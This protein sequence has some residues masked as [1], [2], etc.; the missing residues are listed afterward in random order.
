MRAPVSLP[1]L[2]A[3]VALL[4]APACKGLTPDIPPD[5]A[6]ELAPVPVTN[7]GSATGSWADES[8]NFGPYRVTDVDRKAN[9]STGI[10]VAGHVDSGYNA[11]TNQG[12]YSYTFNAPGGQTRA[13]CSAALGEQR[14][15][16]AGY[17]ENANDG[18][19]GCR[20]V[21]AGLNAAVV[22]AGPGAAWRGQANFHGW[23]MPM[24]AIDRYKNGIYS[25]LPLV[26]DV[27]AP[28]Q[29][30]LAAVELKRPG[31]VWFSPQLD[32]LTHAEIACLFAGYLLFE[33]PKPPL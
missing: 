13:E 1:F 26:I 18:R 27:R 30:V 10:K 24:Q 15:Q 11:N 19:M 28:D 3:F 8:F 20:C 14:V 16:V 12:G 33:N 2:F 21:G 5:I 25:D 7:R 31:K 22:L 29:R 23:P 32:A 4:S 6:R 17:G 9:I